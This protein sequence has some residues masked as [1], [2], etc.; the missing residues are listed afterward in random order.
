[1]QIT[2][3]YLKYEALFLLK[4][5][6]TYAVC[7]VIEHLKLHTLVGH[8]CHKSICYNLSDSNTNSNT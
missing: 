8:L 1:M 6:I 5:N 4:L 3:A 7:T 2:V